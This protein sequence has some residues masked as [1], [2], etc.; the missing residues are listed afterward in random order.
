MG[1]TVEQEA[2]VWVLRIS[3]LL[4]KSELDQLQAAAAKELK[5]GATAKLLIVAEDF[6]GWE[7]GA[8]WGDLAFFLEHGN[9]IEKIAIVSDAKW[10]S[11]WL[12][13]SGAGFRRAP[14]KYFPTGHAD[15]L[16]QARAWLA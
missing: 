4:R 16:A 7:R 13:F 15:Q 14:V 6:E 3:G 8:D 5:T 1:L 12:A 9:Q 10:K 11:E 2:G